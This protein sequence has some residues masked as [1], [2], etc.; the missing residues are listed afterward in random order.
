MRRG[1]PGTIVAA[2]R[3]PL[4]AVESEPA[5]LVAAPPAG[6]TER[7]IAS[8]GRATDPASLLAARVEVLISHEHERWAS[9]H[10]ERVRGN[11][12]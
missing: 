10:E 5:P 6:G 11:P 7:P 12:G 1:A 9:R 2:K 3:F 8:H 4:V